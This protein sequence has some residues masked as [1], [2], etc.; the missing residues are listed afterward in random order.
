MNAIINHVFER[1]GSL[2][3]S[4]TAGATSI[5]GFIQSAENR[6]IVSWGMSL[7]VGVVSLIAGITTIRKN[8]RK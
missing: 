5:V 7:I 2:L 3:L 1:H 8:L 6:S 4:V